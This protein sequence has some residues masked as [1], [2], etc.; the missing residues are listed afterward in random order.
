MKEEILM[1]AKKEH[2]QKY[3]HLMSQTVDINTSLDNYVAGD[4]TPCT[5]IIDGVE[6]T[7]T[8][9]MVRSILNLAKGT[10]VTMLNILSHE[11]EQDVE[12]REKEQRKKEKEQKKQEENKSNSTENKETEN[13]EID[14]TPVIEEDKDTVEAETNTETEITYEEVPYEED[15]TPT[16]EPSIE[17]SE[18]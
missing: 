16:I 11:I 2:I 1:K 15:T 10:T 3:N 18:K 17:K 12:L 14:I 4:L 8:R 6:Y 13:T 9:N 7:L 5:V